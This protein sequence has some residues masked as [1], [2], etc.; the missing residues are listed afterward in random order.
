MAFCP[1]G[2]A[3]Y[4]QTDAVNSGTYLRDGSEVVL[5]LTSPYAEEGER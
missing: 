4:K 3:S 2:E 5:D 1:G